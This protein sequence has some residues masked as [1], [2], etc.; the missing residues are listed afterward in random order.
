[1]SSRFMPAFVA[2]IVWLGLM[3]SYQTAAQQNRPNVQ[4]ATAN[5]WP[6]FRGPSGQGTTE[7]ELPLSWSNQENIAWKKKLPG[8]G[9]SSPIVYGEHIYLTAYSGFYVPDQPEGSQADLKRHLLCL[10]RRNGQEVWQKTAPAKL[11]EEERIRD[12]GFAASTPVIDDERIYCFFGKT[13]VIAFD[14]A[15]IQLWEADV[16][17]KTN[18]WGS[19][20][21]PV[22][23]KDLLLINASVE[24]DSLLA[25][26]KKNGKEVWRVGSI[27][28]SWN[29]PQVITNVNGKPELVVATQGSIQAF[30]IRTPDES[31]GSG[32]LFGALGWRT[33]VLP[34]SSRQ[35]LC[36]C[37]KARICRTSSC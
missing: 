34:K 15:G 18:G 20:A 36:R 22:L 19:A 17:S 32:L 28:E 7:A 13:G 27:K 5:N 35:N 9:A 33:H 16:G 21:S 25:L 23:Y 30:P 6:G 3:S 37:S 1:M 4:V 11:P 29:T 2:A 10:D 12:H 31:R 8:P 26:N 14:H 24:S